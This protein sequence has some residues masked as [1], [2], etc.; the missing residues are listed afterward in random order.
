MGSLSTMS[1][2]DSHDAKARSV[3]LPSIFLKSPPLHSRESSSSYNDSSSVRF[4]V[5][6]ITLEKDDNII[7]VD[8]D[9]T[10]IL[11]HVTTLVR[12][13]FAMTARTIHA[14]T[15]TN[16]TATAHPEAGV[17]HFR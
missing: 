6:T 8:S 11:L 10:L 3:R 12:Q 13:G 7:E 4:P 17:C 2:Q 1:E 9:A 16:V 14:L 15:L 5:N